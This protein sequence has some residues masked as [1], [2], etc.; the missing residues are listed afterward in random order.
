[1]VLSNIQ[2]FALDMNK[3]YC[4]FCEG[5]TPPTAL[6]RAPF[7]KLR[8]H[9]R[10][11]L[12]QAQKT[13]RGALRELNTR[14]P[15]MRGFP[16]QRPRFVALNNGFSHYHLNSYRTWA[17]YSTINRIKSKTTEFK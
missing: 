1:M 7:D 9:L 2:N 5:A 6:L 8:E 14:L 13:L 4:I 12:R 15:P 10:Q 16:P 17:D 3:F 11:A